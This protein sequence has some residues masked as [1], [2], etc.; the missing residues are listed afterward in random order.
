MSIIG[1]GEAFMLASGDDAYNIERSL[2]FNSADST[3]LSKNSSDG[4][5]KTFSIS[6]WIKKLGFQY[7]WPSI[8]TS[9]L[10]TNNRVAI[11]WNNDRLQFYALVGGT[12]KINLVPS[13]KFRDYA[14]WTHC[15]FTADT[16]AANSSDRA[17]IWIN[18][19]LQ[20][21]FDYAGYPDQNDTLFINLLGTTANIGRRPYDASNYIDG[22]LAEFHLL[23]GIAVSNPDG[24]FGEFSSDTGIWNPIKYSGSYGSSASGTMYSADLT[25]NTGKFNVGSG[26][27]MA[28]DG[29]G[30]GA[31]RARAE[32]SYDNYV[33]F[34]PSTPI[35][36]TNGV[37]V[38][39]YAPNG[40]TITNY[41]SVDLDGNGLGSETSFTGGSAGFNDVAWVQVATGSGTLHKVRIRLTRTSDPANA[42]ITAIGINGTAD[43][44]LLV[45]GT[46]A[47]VNGFHLDFADNSAAYK[48]GKDKA[49]TETALPCVDFDGNDHLQINY[50]SDFDFGA[51]DFTIECFA[52]TLDAT[53]NY[54]SIV[55]RWGPS[56]YIWDF[57]PASDDAS[58]NFF[59]VY[60]NGSGNQTVN[61]GV[62]ITDGKWHHLVVARQ[63]SNLRMFVDGALVHTHNIGTD[64]IANNTSQNL[65]L[66][67][68]A[69]GLSYYNGQTSNLRIVKGTAL[70]TAAFTKPTTPLTN[71]TGTK[72]LCFQSDTSVTTAATTPSALYV[73]SGDPEARSVS[74]SDW[75]VNNISVSDLL[76]SGNSYN[77]SLGGYM[78][79]GVARATDPS[80]LADTSNRTYYFLVDQNNTS[81]I[82]VVATATS[83]TTGSSVYDGWGSNNPTTTL[84]NGAVTPN[85]SGSDT[86]VTGKNLATNT[87][88]GL[89]IGNTYTISTKGGG[90]G[91]PHRVHYVTGA[92]V[93]NQP[94]VDTDCVIDSPT[95]YETESGNNGGNYCTLNDLARS[96]NTTL[97]QGAL[98][99]TSNNNQHHAV[100]GTFALSSGKWYY[101]MVLESGAAAP[102][103]GWHEVDYTAA[104]LQNF[105]GSTRPGGYC[106]STNGNNSEIRSYNDGTMTTISATSWA[107]GDVIGCAIDMDAKKIWFRKNGS[108]WYAATNGGTS[109][110]PVT[111]ANPTLTYSYSG[112]LTPR[113]SC[114]SNNYTPVINF[115]ARSFAYTPP[116]GFLSLCTQNI[117]DSLITKPSEYFDTKLYTGNNSSQTISGFNFSPDWAWIKHRPHSYG[118]RLWDTVRGATKRLESHDYTPEAVEATGL[119]AFT[120][121]GFSVGSEANVN[122][123]ANGGAFVAWCWDGGDYNNT[124]ASNSYDQS[125]VWTEIATLSGGYTASGKGLVNGFDGTTTTATEGDSNNEYLEIPISATIASGGVRVYAAVTS[126]NPLYINLYNGSS[127]VETVT[128]SNSGGQWYATTYAGAITK[129]RI[130]RSGRPFEFNAVEV[131]GKI[132]VN[133][134]LITV[135]G[136]N[137]SFYN[138]SAI[139]S[140]ANNLSGDARPQNDA[141]GPPKMFNGILGGESTS[142]APCWSTYSSNSVMTWTSPVTFNNL[143]SLQIHVTKSGTGAGYLRVNGNNYDNLAADDTLVTI[144]E[145]SLSTIAFGYTGG[146]N[147]AT[148]VAG[149]YVNGKLLVNSN[150]NP[151]PYPEIASTCRTNQTAGFSIVSWQANGANASIAHNLNAQVAF[152]IVKMRNSSSNTNWCVYHK[153]LTNAAY[154]LALDSTYFAENN[155]T[156]WNSKDPTSSV[157]F[158]GT[159]GS[160]GEA[161]KNLIGYIFA[162]VKGYSSF[163]KANTTGTAPIMCYTGFA[164][165]WVLIK[166]TTASGPN[167]LIFDTE[168]DPENLAST[169]IRANVAGAE[170]DNQ[171][172]NGSIDFLSNGF[173]IRASGSSSSN[174][175]INIPNSSVIWAAFAENPFKIARAK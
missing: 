76:S 125:Q 42:G 14:G 44:N 89:T 83:I 146:L 102:D 68:D 71:V 117:E 91:N 167:W 160:V 90:A 69:G 173:S 22:Y 164:P 33:E 140:D 54:P 70:Y 112:L 100:L 121:D 157:F 75:Y 52:K 31:S 41:W 34:A 72:L 151:P 106:I 142:G 73:A 127:N 136:A 155:P 170:I 110:N 81:N 99:V 32:N 147:T 145:T 95:N 51:G 63:S 36:F 138:Q 19:E 49:S 171:T 10:D 28:F 48:L 67:Y 109:G 87:F 141:Y 46:P 101:E 130:E 29:N 172:A 57:R 24:V 137:S 50:H 84:N 161:N 55:G 79:A 154:T 129:I 174:T 37:H 6:F 62:S 133:A 120:S 61:S 114:Y 115:G 45:D 126:S 80:Q 3:Y 175:T 113:T 124:F 149:V 168:R 82:T 5:G 96:S 144:P 152:M 97:S 30:S 85:S 135:G 86:S 38:K 25:T 104:Q 43:S 17:K 119:T 20:D 156:T 103:I 56:A 163:G 118:H 128:G 15:L 88:T 108:A 60:N 143:T 7:E 139:W 93:Q 122:T 158:T 98:R 105:P 13:R 18:G 35:S 27:W 40:F 4:N 58:H 21:T 150:G 26:P 132:L 66:G 116:T 65:Y 148:G 39:C 107:T 162:E 16:T 8:F 111:G 131:N 23:D 64:T 74:D 59:F 134:G 47:G 94:V 11:T 9:S 123:N 2:R 77:G 53:T 1:G 12:Q 92:T 159:R 153:D 166:D 165:R 78:P 169:F